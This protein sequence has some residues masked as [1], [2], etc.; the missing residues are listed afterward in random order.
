MC[1]SFLH[2]RFLFNVFS[3]QMFFSK[4]YLKWCMKIIALFSILRMS[5]QGFFKIVKYKIFFIKCLRNFLH[6]HL[7]WIKKCQKNWWHDQK[8]GDIIRW[9]RRWISTERF[10]WNMVMKP[11]IWVGCKLVCNIKLREREFRNWLRLLTEK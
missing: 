2:R 5:I 1:F 10:F 11:V 6:K 3:K 9:S 7:V 8:L 4:T